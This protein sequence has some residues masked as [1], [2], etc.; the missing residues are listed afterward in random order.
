MGTIT[1]GRPIHSVYTH[2]HTD[3]QTH[4]HTH[5]L[6]TSHTDF[7]LKIHR[8]NP[9]THSNKD[10]HTYRHKHTFVP[11]HKQSS[12]THTHSLRFKIWVIGAHWANDNTIGRRWDCVRVQDCT[13]SVCHY[14]GMYEWGAE[15]ECRSI[16]EVISNKWTVRVPV[17]IYSSLLTRCI[18]LNLKKIA[19]TL[20]FGY[21]HQTEIKGR[22]MTAYSIY[23]VASLKSISR[24]VFARWLLK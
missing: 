23:I 2:T 24:F 8:P 17:S 6:Q 5:G 21:L 7:I 14:V 9:I 12:Q 11:A 16:N 15:G 20:G 22:F 4:R 19:D 13:V 18:A 1:A 3:T 10:T